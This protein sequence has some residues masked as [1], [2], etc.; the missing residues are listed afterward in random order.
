MAD[1]LEPDTS[2]GMSTHSTEVRGWLHTPH[3]SPQRTIIKPNTTTVRRLRPSNE[4]VSTARHARDVAALV[5]LNAPWDI[6]YT[7]ARQHILRPFLALVLSPL[8][9]Q[10]RA[11]TG[12]DVVEVCVSEGRVEKSVSRK[13]Y[14]EDRLKID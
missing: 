9:S 7:K 4:C 2:T 1:I 8:L 6:R 14:T 11:R 10:Q 3:Y 13:S 5:L 12:G